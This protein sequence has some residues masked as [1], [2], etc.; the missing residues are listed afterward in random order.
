MTKIKVDEQ[1]IPEEPEKAQEF[2]WQRV[3]DPWVVRIR[4]VSPWKILSEVLAAID[5]ASEIVD[6]VTGTVYRSDFSHNGWV[7]RVTVF[8]SAGVGP[9]L[10]AWII[11]Y[12]DRSLGTVARML[13]EPLTERCPYSKSI[14]GLLTDEHTHPNPSDIAFDPCPTDWD[15]NE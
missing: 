14:K 1:T 11:S 3:L 9:D 2:T 15:R 8:C 12:L 4:Q 5:F 13:E 6:R 10:E 7:I